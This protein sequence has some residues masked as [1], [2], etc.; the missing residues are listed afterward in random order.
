MTTD[1][2]VSV[3]TPVDMSTGCIVAIFAL[4]GP[5]AGSLPLML[6]LALFEKSGE[7]DE[8][9]FGL[10]LAMG[11]IFG[12]LPAALTGFAVARSRGFAVPTPVRGALFGVIVAA[13]FSPVVLGGLGG[14]V[15]FTVFGSI[16]GMLCGL[17]SDGVERLASRRGVKASG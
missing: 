3:P 6:V 15:L 2:P 16:A 12:T 13:L 7:S 1:R 4:L 14:F 8:S 17:V 10:V 11:Y 5:L 9:L